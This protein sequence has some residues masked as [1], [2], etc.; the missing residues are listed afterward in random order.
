V[1]S[2]EGELPRIGRQCVQVGI[3]PVRIDH[4]HPGP[5]PG[6]E[7]VEGQWNHLGLGLALDD[8]GERGLR[9]Q[10]KLGDRGLQ[11]NIPPWYAVVPRV[12]KPLVWRLGRPCGAVLGHVL[13]KPEE[14]L[15]GDP[16][17]QGK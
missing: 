1:L 11:A 15:A 14:H 16:V 12:R 3:D 2:T 17:V 13:V 9:G 8:Q 10:P 7:R 5:P 4:P 6:D